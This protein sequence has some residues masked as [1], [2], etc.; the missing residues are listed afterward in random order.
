MGYGNEVKLLPEGG[1]VGLEKPFGL[2]HSS[3]L[4]ISE[5][6]HP[7]APD[8]KM[9]RQVLLVEEAPA[10]HRARRLHSVPFSPLLFAQQ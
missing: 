7:E 10:A 5:A 4:F 1:R 8:N 3:T 2:K 6:V 9:Y